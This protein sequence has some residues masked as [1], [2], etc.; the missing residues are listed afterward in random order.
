MGNKQVVEF[1]KINQ[2]RKFEIHR[3]KISLFSCSFLIGN[4][5][6]LLHSFLHEDFPPKISAGKEEISLVIFS[7]NGPAGG[8]EG[9]LF[10]TMVAVE[11][12]KSLLFRGCRKQSL[13]D[14]YNPEWFFDYSNIGKIDIMFLSIYVNGKRHIQFPYFSLVLITRDLM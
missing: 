7:R 14:G 12:C 8:W 4:L 1:L 6:N 13:M 3:L 11:Q 10:V 9:I 5:Q 2:S